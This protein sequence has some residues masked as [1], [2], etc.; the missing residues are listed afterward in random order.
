MGQYDLPENTQPEGTYKKKVKAQN[1]EKGD[2]TTSTGEKVLNVWP[3]AKGMSGKLDMSRVTV[4]LEKD[5]KKRIGLRRK[6][7]NS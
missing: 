7:S 5:G 2:I 3:G 1:V 6:N 4:E